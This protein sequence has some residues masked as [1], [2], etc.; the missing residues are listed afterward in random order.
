MQLIYIHLQYK[1]IRKTEY[2]VVS[3]YYIIIWLYYSQYDIDSRA[4]PEIGILGM[5]PI[6]KFLLL[7]LKITIEK[8]DNLRVWFITIT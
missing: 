7:E 8:I 1:H 2:L 4:I 5:K 6:I 3:M